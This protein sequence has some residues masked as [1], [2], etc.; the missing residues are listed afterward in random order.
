MAH[1]YV[2][3]WFKSNFLR[4]GHSKRVQ[5]SMKYIL[6]MNHFDDYQTMRRPNPVYE[7]SQLCET[8][9]EREI[10]HG[11]NI[12]ILIN[13]YKPSAV[14]GSYRNLIIACPTFISL[15]SF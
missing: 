1:E 11:E 8:S 4:L 12:E 7:Y 10:G 9:N 6:L 15:Q 5:G 2:S 14:E 3:V 13:V